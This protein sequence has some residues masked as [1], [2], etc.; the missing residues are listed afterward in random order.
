[1]LE[2]CPKPGLRTA[3]TMTDDDHAM[4]PQPPSPKAPRA[5]PAQLQAMNELEDIEETYCPPPCL[6]DHAIMQR[7]RRIFKRRANGEYIQGISQELVDMFADVDA[8][9]D[10]IK[11]MFEKAGYVPDL[12]SKF[13]PCSCCMPHLIILLSCNEIA[14]PLRRSLCVDAVG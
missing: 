3:P 6:T 2:A 10:K 12:G 7:L 9:R 8:G 5:K 1:M 13:A 11:A 4:A 14:N